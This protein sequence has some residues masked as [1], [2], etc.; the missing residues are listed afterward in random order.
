MTTS[1]P[2]SGIHP[3]LWW[4][5]LLLVP[6]VAVLWV[7]WYNHL[8]PRFIGIP[9]LYWYLLMWVPLSAVCSAVVYFKTRDLT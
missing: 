7:P 5:L 4:R 1:Q 8:D 2:S 3:R 6:I 9:F